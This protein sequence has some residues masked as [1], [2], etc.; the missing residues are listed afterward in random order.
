MTG[1]AVLLSLGVPAL[2][3]ACWALARRQPWPVAPTGWPAAP[4]D[5]LLIL[6]LVAL[7]FGL[8]VWAWQVAGYAFTVALYGSGTDGP[9]PSPEA[10]PDVQPG[11]SGRSQ[12]PAPGREDQGRSTS[13]PFR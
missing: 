9:P 6:L 10:G 7:F 13:P 3:G 5:L 11:R 8:S 4:V 2:G 12:N 1:S